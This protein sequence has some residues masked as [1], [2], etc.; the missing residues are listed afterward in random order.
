MSRRR[1]GRA[2]ASSGARVARRPAHGDA[3][4]SPRGHLADIGVV[5]AQGEQHAYD[6]KR[7]AVDG[8]DEYS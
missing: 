6:L 8:F 7:L 1:P 5:E 2:D 4:R 3:Q